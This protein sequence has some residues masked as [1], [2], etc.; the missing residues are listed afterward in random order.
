MKKKKRAWNC[1]YL[2]QFANLNAGHLFE[3]VYYLKVL[4]SVTGFMW[5]CIIYIKFATASFNWI[6]IER[7]KQLLFGSW[8]EGNKPKELK[9]RSIGTLIIKAGTCFLFLNPQSYHCWW[10][11]LQAARKWEN[12]LQLWDF[13]VRKLFKSLSKGFTDRSFLNNCEKLKGYLYF[14]DC[15]TRLIEPEKLTMNWVF[16]AI[17]WVCCG[18]QSLHWS[19]YV[20]KNF[21][22]IRWMQHDIR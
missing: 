3:D 11:F 8:R 22:S 6:F 7:Q 17:Y 12:V 15:Q 14:R 21:Y 13:N 2:L 18:R 4:H 20:Y 9:C 1:K 10:S 19:F 5:S 16:P